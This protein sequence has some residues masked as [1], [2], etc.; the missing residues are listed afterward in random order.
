VCCVTCLDTAR[1]AELALWSCRCACGFVYLV[2]N[3]GQPM[4]STTCPTCKQARLGGTSHMPHQQQTM[5]GRGM[6]AQ[7]QPGYLLPEPLQAGTAVR[8]LRPAVLHLLHLLQHLLL[9]AGTEL[10]LANGQSLLPAASDGAS[11]SSDGSAGSSGLAAAAVARQSWGHLQRNLSCSDDATLA[12]AHEA[13]RLLFEQQAA[14]LPAAL[15]SSA[16]RAA[17]EQGFT[18]HVAGP[19]SSGP[20]QLLRQLADQAAAAGAAARSYLEGAI[21]ELLP[22]AMLQDSSYRLSSL[23]RLLRCM[24]LPTVATVLLLVSNQAGTGSRHV[25]LLQELM[26]ALHPD[27]PL[28]LLQHLP[29]LVDWAMLAQQHLGYSLC[30]RQAQQL[31]IEQVLAQHGEAAQALTAALPAFLTAWNACRHI[32]DG[33]RCT[34]FQGGIPELGPGSAF[35]LCCIGSQ[36]DGLYLRAMVERLVQLQSTWLRRCRA[37][38]LGQPAAGGAIAAGTGEGPQAAEQQQEEV[39]GVAGAGAGDAAGE[40]GGDQDRLPLQR[41]EPDDVIPAAATATRLQQQLLAAGLAVPQLEHGSGTALRLDLPRLTAWLERRLLRNRVLL[42]SRTMPDFCFQQEIFRSVATLLHDV[43]LK[44]PQQPLPPQAAARGSSQA[45][46]GGGPGHGQDNERG[47]GLASGLE[48]Q[49]ATKLKA[50]VEVVLSFVAMTGAQPGQM[51][52]E[53]AAAWLPDGPARQA[54]G[55]PGCPEQFRR[56]PMGQVVAAYEALEDVLLGAALQCTHPAYMVPLPAE[57]LQAAR[58]AMG[59]QGHAGSS[60]AGAAGVCS[61]G[62]SV[63]PAADMQVVLGRFISRFLC[64]AQQYHKGGTP[65][66]L[67]LADERCVRWPTV[68]GSEGVGGSDRGATAGVSSS[69]GGSMEDVVD[70]VLS[71][72]V[73]LEHAH[74]VYQ[75]ALQH[76]G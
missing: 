27:S 45:P 16:A 7:E 58:R 25:Q 62:R 6:V 47:Q 18:L 52:V 5:L 60:T 53:Y 46:G 37:L 8:Q 41:L 40:A 9:A 70:E 63:I 50:A 67:Y 55:G 71:E 73:L 26:S 68:S 14:G 10:G 72:E 3:C 66:K 23:P 17:W 39:A 74:A 59:L 34:A 30:R 13:V 65:L 4:E 33:Y 28:Q 75:L 32:T 35:C 49:Q 48:P 43:A 56:L 15:P 31:S 20:Q 21:S 76:C 11:S 36:D 61:S 19:A 1:L 51:L 24:Q 69:G 12:V 22:A 54:L 64:S 42:G 57:A 44:V 38:Q 2:G 29:A